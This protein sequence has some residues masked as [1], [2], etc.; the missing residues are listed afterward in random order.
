M[1][2]ISKIGTVDSDDIEM[3]MGIGYSDRISSVLGVDVPDDEGGGGQPSSGADVGEYGNEQGASANRLWSG[4]QNSGQME[5]TLDLSSSDYADADLA[6]N[7]QTI[8]FFLRYESGSGYRNDPQLYQIDFDNGGWVTVGASSGGTWG[9][10][11]WKTTYRT[12]NQAYDHDASFS[13]VTSS[14]GPTGKWHRDTYSTP[15]GGTGVSVSSHIYYEGSNNGYS[16]D[17]YLRSP[18]FTVTTNTVKLRCYGYGSNMGSIYAGIYVT[19]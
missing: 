2:D 5:F 4:N 7:N 13:T 1:P 17:V 15:S 8:H 16:K 12:T 3:V 9:Y 18:E 6:D 11:Q 19:G 14:T 10:G